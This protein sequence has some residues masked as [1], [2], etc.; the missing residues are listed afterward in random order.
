MIIE[1]ETQILLTEQEW[2]RNARPL[3][4]IPKRWR[5][6]IPDAEPTRLN[7]LA[8]LLADAMQRAGFTA[9]PQEPAA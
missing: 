9:E 5:L 8:A 6:D 7:E 1:I 4:A 2:A 3:S